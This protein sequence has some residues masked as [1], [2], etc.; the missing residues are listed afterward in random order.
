MA[1]NELAESIMKHFVLCEKCFFKR[2]CDKDP[3][4]VCIECV[5]AF[6]RSPVE[7]SEK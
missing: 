1:D 6:L 2:R 5:L 4:G 7:E 3:T